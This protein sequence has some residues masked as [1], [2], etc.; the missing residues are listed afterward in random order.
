MVLY[1]GSER[2]SRGR[3]LCVKLRN[4]SGDIRFELRIFPN[5]VP[6]MSEGLQK[7]RESQGGWHG[8][9]GDEHVF[10]NV[11][12]LRRRMRAERI[13]VRNLVKRHLPLEPLQQIVYFL[14]IRV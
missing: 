4:Q 13:P 12:A 3:S 7:L 2:L 9:S 5:Q 14:G 10:I 11:S 6:G 1:K 8:S